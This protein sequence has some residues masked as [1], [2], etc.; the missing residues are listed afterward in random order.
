MNDNLK[1]YL[2]ELPCNG[3][4]HWMAQATQRVMIYHCGIPFNRIKWHSGKSGP[5]MEPTLT[6]KVMCSEKQLT[7]IILKSGAIIE[8]ILDN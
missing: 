5:N 8:K 3:L 2:L 4:N 1:Q 7:M 6:W